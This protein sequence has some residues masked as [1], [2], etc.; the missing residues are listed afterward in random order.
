EIIDGRPDRDAGAPGDAERGRRRGRVERRERARERQRPAVQQ[1]H[2]AAEHAQRD[3]VLHREPAERCEQVL[4]QV[5]GL[6]PVAHAYAGVGPQELELAARAE[7]ALQGEPDGARR[8]HELEAARP[9]AVQ[10]GAEQPSRA[11]GGRCH[12]P[13]ISNTLTTRINAKSITSPTK[14]I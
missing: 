6:R 7:L 10:A 3:P 9:A 13:R 1:G 11:S 4:D 8:A 2:L 5:H 12:W 14:W